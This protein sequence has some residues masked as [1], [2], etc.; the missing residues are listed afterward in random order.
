MMRLCCYMSR[1]ALGFAIKGF[2]SEEGL[3]RGVCEE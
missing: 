1:H 3:S 2:T